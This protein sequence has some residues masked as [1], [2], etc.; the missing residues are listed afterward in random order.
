MFLGCLKGKCTKYSVGFNKSLIILYFL[1]EVQL[2]GN[3][4]RELP[5]EFTSG[6]VN[7]ELLGLSENC[8]ESLPKN[9]GN[10]KKLQ[11]L[12]ANNNK[13][14]TLPESIGNLKDL[15]LFEVAGNLLQSLPDTISMFEFYAQF[16]YSKV[17]SFRQ[18]KCLYPS[19]S[20]R[21]Q[22]FGVSETD[23]WP[24]QLGKFGS[25]KESSQKSSK[26]LEKVK[27]AKTSG[28]NI[29]CIFKC[30]YRV[31]QAFIIRHGQFHGEHVQ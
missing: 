31:L 15:E 24:S 23:S 22:I 8:L 30:M 25:F 7:L 11:I 3:S 17:L 2:S 10:L 5:E 19:K 29:D 18:T 16:P 12:Y 9:I 28:K 14:Q 21:K 27:K 4:L 20:Q 1:Q 13:F 6:L 26:G